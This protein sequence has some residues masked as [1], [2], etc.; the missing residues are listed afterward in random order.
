MSATR[1]GGKRGRPKKF[2]N[3]FLDKVRARL[4]QATTRASRKD[5]EVMKRACLRIPP[6]RIP[7]KDI[8][9]LEGARKHLEEMFLRAPNAEALVELQEMMARLRSRAEPRA[10]FLTCVFEAIE[11]IAK[12]SHVWQKLVYDARKEFGEDPAPLPKRSK[13]TPANS[14]AGSGASAAAAAASKSDPPTLDLEDE[15]DDDEPASQVDQ[16][17][18]EEEEEEEGEEGH[19]PA[20]SR[21]W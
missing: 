18:E 12:D 2:E 4:A 8:G 16:G 13:S 19:S 15:N 1:G 3:V 9:T 14:R 6:G 10:H 7:A 17:G 20:R 5:I 11:E 21:E